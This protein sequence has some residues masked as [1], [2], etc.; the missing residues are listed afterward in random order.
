MGLKKEPVIVQAILASTLVSAVVTALVG[1]LVFHFLKRRDERKRRTFEVRYAEYKH[2]LR[3]IESLA[4][5][6]HA[7]LER[8]M[9]ESYNNCM[10]DIFAGSADQALLKMSREL[11]EMTSRATKSFQQATSELHGLRLVCSE[12]LFGMVNDFIKIQEQLMSETT[13]SLGAVAANLGKDHTVVNESMRL[14][15]YAAKALFEKIIV[16][17]RRELQIQ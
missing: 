14:K 13:Q 10:E 16:Q 3:A 5:V 8:F 4:S 11:G 1:P 2:Y 12:E 7:D 6:S 15:G 17:M 9:R